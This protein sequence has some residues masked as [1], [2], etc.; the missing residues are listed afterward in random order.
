VP[1]ILTAL[2]EFIGVL[3]IVL[4]GAGA[5]AAALAALSYAVRTRR[6]NPFSPV[7]RVTRESIDPLFAPVERRVVRAGGRPA[8]APWW[9]LAALVVGGIVLISVLGYVRQMI[10]MAFLAA[11]LGAPGLVRLL[12]QWTFGILQLALLV[13]V[14]SSWIQLGA[15]SRW[16]RWSFVLTDWMLAPL[17]QIIP[18]LG[19]MDVTPI[20]A[21][22]LLSLLERFVVGLLP[23]V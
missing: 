22:F 8:T 6:L 11:G 1:F 4:F 18:P 19:M 14:I 17:R 3:R 7:A 5:L 21:Y 23:P 10:A 20:A 9:A 15:Y 2:D 12:V 13:R 16:V